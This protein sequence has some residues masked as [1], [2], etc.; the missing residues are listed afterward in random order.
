MVYRKILTILMAGLVLGGMEITHHIQ[1][2]SIPENLP[3]VAWVGANQ[4]WV[5]DA[6]GNVRV[7]VGEDVQAAALSP[8]RTQIAYHTG[9]NL[10]VL[11]VDSGDVVASLSADIF[12]ANPAIPDSAPRFSTPYW[13]SD[14]T[15]WFNTIDF[16][17]SAYGY[18]NRHDIQQWNI[19]ENKP[20]EIAPPG[21]GGVLLPSPDHSKIAVYR[22]GHYQD[23]SDPAVI[24]ILDV[25]TGE[26]IGDPI[27]FPTVA[28]GSEVDW[29]PSITWSQSSDAIGFSIPDPDLLYF[30]ADEFPTTQI[31]VMAI[32]GDTDCQWPSIA[33]PAQPIFEPDLSAWAALQPDSSGWALVI[34]MASDESLEH[35]RVLPR[36][37]LFP[38]M[39]NHILVE[40]IDW[41][42]EAHFLVRAI[43][44]DPPQTQILSV[45]VTSGTY[46]AWPDE[47]ATSVITNLQPLGDSLYAIAYG[48][49]SSTQV[50]IYDTVAQIATPLRMPTT[51]ENVGW[52]AFALR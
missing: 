23:F 6:N 32:R 9:E 35:L 40:P 33:F 34:G 8:N 19:A 39:A 46:Q 11:A 24:E 26:I 50:M 52:I 42:D 49:F 4:L 43:F 25:A 31:C 2:Q 29:F 47:T 44:D 36:D 27:T 15:L 7:R 16:Y 51:T 48:D 30:A 37:V 14:T 18:E 17:T 22:P 41:L 28:T 12:L 10:S 45:D 1:A 20:T 21:A 5:S 13:V 38:R 3:I